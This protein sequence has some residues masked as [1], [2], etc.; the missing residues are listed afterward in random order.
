MKEG[1]LVLEG[2]IE[3]S[4]AAAL[5]LTVFVPEWKSDEGPMP[6]AANRFARVVGIGKG[7]TNHMRKREE[8]GEQE[9]EDAL[10]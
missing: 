3:T 5:V 4:I 1:V 6:A 10:V 7:G 8:E 2:E 9:Q